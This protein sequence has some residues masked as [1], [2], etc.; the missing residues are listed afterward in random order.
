MSV[1]SGAP[2]AAGLE[3]SDDDFKY[4][5]V[6]VVRQ[7][8]VVVQGGRLLTRCCALGPPVY[9]GKIMHHVFRVQ[10]LP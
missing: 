2:S 5:E 4:E 3:D 1:H 7:V 9:M 6:E 10:Y 8:R